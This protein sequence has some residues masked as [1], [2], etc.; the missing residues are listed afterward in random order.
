MQVNVS[1]VATKPTTTERLVLT[2]PQRSDVAELHQL[3]GDPQVWRDDPMTRHS[4]RDQTEG[5]IDRWRD[6][7]LRDALGMWN[8]AQRRADHSRSSGRYRWLL[9]PLW[10][11]VEPRV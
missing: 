6:A 2:V 9:H 11:G 10:R 5:M 4:T 7:W 1:R 3:Y 8:G